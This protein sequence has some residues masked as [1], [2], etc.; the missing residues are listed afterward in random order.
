MSCHVDEDEEDSMG[1]R[2]KRRRDRMMK[3]T[4]NTLLC[5]RAHASCHVEEEKKGK[6]PFTVCHVEEEEG[7]HHEQEEEEGKQHDEDDKR[8]MTV[9]ACWMLPDM[10][11]GFSAMP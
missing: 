11:H 1:G 10:Y 9:P 6:I 2:K 5:V 8:L 3:K 4:S 7:K